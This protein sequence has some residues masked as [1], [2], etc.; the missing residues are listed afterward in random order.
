MTNLT[1]AVDKPYY[2][3]RARPAPEDAFDKSIMDLEFWYP[4]MTDVFESFSQ[5]HGAWSNNT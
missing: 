1:G 4:D 2:E 5:K 3:K